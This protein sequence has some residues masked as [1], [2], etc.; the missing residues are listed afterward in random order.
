MN[1]NERKRAKALFEKLREEEQHLTCGDEAAR[2]YH[3]SH[4][5]RFHK[6]IE[7]CKKLA[8]N[9]HIQV[10]DVGSSFLT[11]LLAQEYEKV[12][13]LGLDRTKDK[14]GQ[15]YKSVN[16]LSLPHIT[17]DL[18]DSPNTNRW[19][20]IKQV[21][22]LIVFAET[23]EH[24]YIATEYSLTFLSS[25]LSKE[26]ILLVTSPNAAM[27]VKRLIL[28]LKGKNPFQQFRLYSE[29]PGHY[30]EYTMKELSEAAARCQLDVIYS[31]YINFHVSKLSFY[32]LLKNIKPSF[33]DSIVLAFRRR[34]Y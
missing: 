6:T 13:T 1:N 27:I 11:K 7:I 14:G 19:P 9:P 30:R 8:P 5:H 16:T 20:K 18:N 4:L 17:F 2:I 21:F 33:K 34:N 26:G 29:N 32:G 3:Q 23:I 10:L 12:Y 31:E 28:L 24:L 22:D 15:Q 25:L